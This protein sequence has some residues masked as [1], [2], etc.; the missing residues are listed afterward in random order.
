MIEYT[1]KI[2]QDF[3]D[4]HYVYSG[5]K[6]VH[7]NEANEENRWQIKKIGREK[8]DKNGQKEKRA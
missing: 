3:L 7:R 5:D 8:R 6:T 1:K 2:G 4:T